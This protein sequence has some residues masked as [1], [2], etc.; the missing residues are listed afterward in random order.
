M[1]QFAPASAYAQQFGV[2]SVI[3]GPPGIGKTPLLNTAPRPILLATEPGLLSMRGSSVMTCLAPTPAEVDDFMRWLASSPEAK[4][5]DTVGVDSGS[6]LAE[7][8]LK[9][10]LSKKSK[11]G[12]KVDGK[13][14]YGEMSVR[15]MEHI[16]T[17]YY[18]MNKHVIIICKEEVFDDNGTTTRRP[19]FPGKDLNVKIPHLFDE[20]LRYEKVN[21]P[22]VGDVKAL[23]AVATYGIIAR[24]RSGRLGEFEQPDLSLL[25]NKILQG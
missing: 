8:I 15:V 5:Y 21:V 25:F 16:N 9:Q 6:Q 19:Y 3:Y 7:I 20:I 2:K 1:P 22:S 10:E 11:S 12:N 18:M 14:A 17:L 13:A 24:D 4:N 23:R